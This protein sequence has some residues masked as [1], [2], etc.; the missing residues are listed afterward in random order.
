MF[1][2]IEI[3]KQKGFLGLETKFVD[4][5]ALLIIDSPFEFN[6]NVKPINLDFSIF[7]DGRIKKDAIG[8]VNMN[9]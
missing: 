4:D 1:Q 2:V 5:V 8:K 3:V 9:I 7:E 6:D